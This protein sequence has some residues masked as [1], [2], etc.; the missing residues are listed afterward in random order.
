M[1][2]DRELYKRA[3]DAALYGPEKKGLSIKGHGF[4]V[5]KLKSI[6]QIDDDTFLASG[7][8][9]HCLNFRPDDQVYYRIFFRKNDVEDLSIQ[10]NKGG[11]D[12]VLTPAYVAGAII[13]SVFNPVAGGAMMSQIAT[14][15]AIMEEIE[16]QSSGNWR[17]VCESIIALTAARL[18]KEYTVPRKRDAALIGE[19]PVEI[20][21]TVDGTLL[22][23]SNFDDLYTYA[24]RRGQE[25]ERT[26]AMAESET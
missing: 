10:V 4:N 7:Q 11:W 15:D 6:V 21:L 22:S 20:S 14:F 17:N 16:A 26:Y 25:A 5:K 24:F 19:R 18:C 3:T 8:I 9:S 13:L 1:A 23:I 12:K 2:T